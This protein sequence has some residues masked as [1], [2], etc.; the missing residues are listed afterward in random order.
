MTKREPIFVGI[1]GGTASGKTTV[2][3]EIFAT[4]RVGQDHECCMIPFDSFYNEC[5]DE[6]IA[7]IKNVNFDHPEIFDFA[8]LRQTLK[9]LKNGEDVEIPEYDYTTCKR[10]K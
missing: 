8:L 10:K 5:T 2:T 9:K 1:A 6:Q 3:E 4:V 7:D